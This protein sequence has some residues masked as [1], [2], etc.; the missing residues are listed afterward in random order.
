MN[1]QADKAGLFDTLSVGI[2][3]SVDGKTRQVVSDGYFMGA[4]SGR[5]AR[6]VEARVKL[7]P[8]LLLARGTNAM[9]SVRW[10]GA[11]STIPRSSG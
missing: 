6:F 3:T 7:M 8:S 2:R 9:E 1:T 10:P 4:P 5:E 11:V